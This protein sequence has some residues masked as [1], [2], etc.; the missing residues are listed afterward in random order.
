MIQSVVLYD[1]FRQSLFVVMC[2]YFQ[3]SGN[4]KRIIERAKRIDSHLKTVRFQFVCN[5]VCKAGADE[6]NPLGIVDFLPCVGNM[7]RGG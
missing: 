6:Q 5:I 2:Q 1:M 7:D 4:A 3:T